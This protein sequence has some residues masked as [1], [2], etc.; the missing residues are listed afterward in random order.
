MH[1]DWFSG[2][3]VIPKG[4]MLYYEHMGY[5]S[6]YEMELN[7][8]IDDGIITEIQKYDNSKTRITYLNSDKLAQ[9][10]IENLDKKFLDSWSTDLKAYV[11]IKSS[12]GQVTSAEITTTNL[13]ELSN[14]II[15]IVNQIVDWDI[16][17]RHGQEAELPWIYPI[18]INKEKIEK[19]SR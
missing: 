17:Y 15:G 5:A 9:F 10:V 18:I 16:L 14:E 1:A 13:P 19:Y 12:N 4:K 11:D 2:E 6:V 7:I 8:K 3:L